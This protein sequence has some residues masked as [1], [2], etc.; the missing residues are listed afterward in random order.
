[1]IDPRTCY[2]DLNGLFGNTHPTS[3]TL[4]G[5]AADSLE[6]IL[7]PSPATG[8]DAD[9]LEVSDPPLGYDAGK[10]PYKPPLRK[11]RLT[12]RAGPLGGL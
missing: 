11:R 9:I 8:H 5:N 2:T 4:V 3:Y 7:R 12:A 10:F 1:V 6:P